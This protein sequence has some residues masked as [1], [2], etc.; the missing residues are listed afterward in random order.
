[1]YKSAYDMEHDD[2][3]QKLRQIVLANLDNENFGVSQLSEHIGMSRSNLFRKLK[4]LTGKSISC[5]I[6]EIRLEKSLELLLNSSDTASEIAYKV[7]FN[8]PS[9]FHKCFYKYYGFHPAEAK[10]QS[11]NILYKR[12][13]S[14]KVVKPGRPWVISRIVYPVVILLIIIFGVGYTLLNTDN[15]QSST[16]EIPIE[17]SIA[18]MP[19]QN[20]SAEEQ[21]QYF[22]D[23]LVD[24]L[25]N[26]LSRVQGISVISRTSSNVY[27]ER[28]SITIPQIA[29]ELNVNY[30]IEGSVQRDADQIRINIQLLNAK[31]DDQIW[32]HIYD[33][34]LNDIFSTQTEIAMTVT[35]AMHL[36]LT[37]EQT[38][39]L[40]SS[41]TKNIKALEY[42]QL[43]RFHHDKMSKESMQIA[44]SYFKEA[45]NED[46]NYARAYLGLADAFNISLDK[47][48]EPN[49]EKKRALALKALELDENLG[50]AHAILALCY[51]AEKN[52]KGAASAYMK[53]INLEPNSPRILRAYSQFSYLIGNK[54]E[55]RMYIDKAIKNDPLSFL[56]HHYSAFIYANE[57]QYEETLEEIIICEELSNNQSWMLIGKSHVNYV[58]GNVS[59][60]VD[61]LKKYAEI[62][63]PKDHSKEIDS[64]YSIKGYEGLL[65]WQITKTNFP[66]YQSELYAYLGDEEM[67]I[68]ALERAFD[69][70]SLND[71]FV[72]RPCYKDYVN[73][74]RFKAIVKK[75]KLYDY[76]YD[77]DGNYIQ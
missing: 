33:R 39:E 48:L 75:K 69:E 21:N 52:W 11:A 43:G 12:I 56:N 73:N 70:N 62:A 45:I 65:E 6:R 38:K 23:G 4:Q 77:K 57:E 18:V 17:K 71:Y 24:D 30:I 37:P 25:I 35:S 7:G 47:P 68:S 72:V 1:M 29:E 51:E 49:I 8:S 50:E 40:S 27:R 42:Y 32:S 61:A 41:G 63:Y 2:L 64:I 5:F 58:L 20:L 31:D 76:Y 16:R 74:P 55:A 15:T 44:M 53:A 34:E 59:E 46:P 13:K 67:S 28:A 14:Q 3:L 36:A 26:R 10:D 9:Y 19:F 60:A 22:V 54:K 66:Q